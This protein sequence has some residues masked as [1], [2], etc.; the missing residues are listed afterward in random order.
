[1]PRPPFSLAFPNLAFK[2]AKM[3]LIHCQSKIIRA[4]LLLGEFSNQTSTSE[5]V[6]DFLLPQLALLY[7]SSIVTEPAAP[8]FPTEVYWFR[9]QSSSGKFMCYQYPG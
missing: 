1:M 9:Q 5:K 2:T 6:P 3:F 8:P 4:N 7:I